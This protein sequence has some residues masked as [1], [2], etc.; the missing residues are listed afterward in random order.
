MQTAIDK[1]TQAQAEPDP[2]DLVNPGELKKAARYKNLMNPAQEEGADD[3]LARQ[4]EQ[5]KNGGRYQPIKDAEGKQ[6]VNLDGP[7][8]LSISKNK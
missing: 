8:R 4:V 1:L 3:L 5:F 6:D 7:Y 2:N